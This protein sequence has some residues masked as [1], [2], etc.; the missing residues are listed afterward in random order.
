MTSYKLIQCVMLA[1]LASAL[2]LGLSALPGRAHAQGSDPASVITAFN[3]AT[4]GATNV[5]ATLALVADDITIHIVPPPPANPSGIFTGK[6]GVRTFVQN[7]AAQN[8][9]RV[10]IGAWQVNGDKVSGTIK[11]TNNDFKKWG[12]GAV[13]HSLE[14]VVQGGKLKSVTFTMSPAE[15]PRVAAA[16]AAAQQAPQTLPT[17]GG[18]G[19]PEAIWV[20]GFGVVLMSGMGLILMRIA[21]R[22]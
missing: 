22:V 9:Q 10:L 1:A 6:E 11:I 2:A 20:L 12:V 17:T 13:E 16:R 18:T 4:S 8:P 15:Q 7:A 5:D 19:G 14:A 3:E 21:R